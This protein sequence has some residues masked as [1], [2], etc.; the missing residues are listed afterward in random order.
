V[1][2]IDEMRGLTDKGKALIKELG[3]ERLVS[4]DYLRKFYKKH[5]KFFDNPKSSPLPF[6][7]VILIGDEAL[8]DLD[9]LKLESDES[10][11]GNTLGKYYTEGISQRANAIAVCQGVYLYIYYQL[12]EIGLIPKPKERKEKIKGGL[13]PAF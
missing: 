13:K 4:E 1:K 8:K 7:K 6:I 3:L 5:R 11:V 12:A 9:K 2:S 10:D